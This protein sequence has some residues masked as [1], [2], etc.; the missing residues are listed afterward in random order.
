MHACMHACS[1]SKT[2]IGRVVHTLSTSQS[3]SLISVA[4]RASLL[5]YQPAHT[6][7]DST[8]FFLLSPFVLIVSHTDDSVR[9]A[10]ER[11]TK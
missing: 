9:R 5:E 8:H 7:L 3:H 11:R 6:M 4:T 2:Y 1:H 10:D